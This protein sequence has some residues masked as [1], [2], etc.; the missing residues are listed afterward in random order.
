M[1][2]EKY[3]PRSFSDCLDTKTNRL[4]MKLVTNF[5]N[6]D[7][8]GNLMLYGSPGC[9]KFLRL[10]LLLKKIVNKNEINEKIK[11]I[12]VETGK[13]SFRTTNRL[14][15]KNKELFCNTSQYHC[16]LDLRQSNVDKVLTKFI[17]Y[18]S[19]TKNIFDNQKILIL[20]GIDFL[21]KQTQNS[22][23]RTIEIYNNIKFF[24]TSSSLS[25]VIQ[26]LRS[27]F[28][29]LNIRSPN[30]K[31]AKNIIR[32]IIG[33]EKSFPEINELSMNEIIKQSK[34]GSMKNIINIKKIL[35]LLGIYKEKNI[36]YVFDTNFIINKIADGVYEKK[37]LNIIR[38]LIYKLY[39]LDNK[40]FKNNITS[41]FFRLYSAKLKDENKLFKFIEITQDFNHKLNLS[42]ITQPILIAE[43]YIFSLYT[44]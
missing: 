32:N 37:D 39:E 21:K 18:Y 10:K 31:E 3:E 38:N 15:S 24:I 36:I 40:K 9:G 28:L 20:R 14:K 6:L 26:P 12:D 13:F 42:Y 16:E 27:R 25:K 35:F 8:I 17:K 1:F 22:L 41:I 5:T 44:L 23:R 30:C 43:S 2:F 11:G 29:C 34:E 7:E 19:K 4:M 33:K